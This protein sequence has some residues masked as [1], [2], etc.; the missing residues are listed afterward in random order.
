MSLFVI[1]TAR[2]RPEG[3][4]V[5]LLQPVSGRCA[6]VTPDPCFLARGDLATQED[7]WH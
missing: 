5:W 3:G 4:P 2:V 1:V 6:Q 7:T